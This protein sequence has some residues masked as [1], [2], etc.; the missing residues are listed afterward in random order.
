MRLFGVHRLE[1]FVDEAILLLQ[2]LK[3]NLISR[4]RL[5]DFF[6]LLVDLGLGEKEMVV[7][8]LFLEVVQL[9]LVH[10]DDSS[11]TLIPVQS[12]PSK[13]AIRIGPTII[14]LGLLVEISSPNIVAAGSSIVYRRVRKLP[15][16]FKHVLVQLLCV[17]VDGLIYRF[18]PT[19]VLFDCRIH[20]TLQFYDSWCY[21]FWA[22]AVIFSVFC[23]L[24]VLQRC[25]GVTDP[26]LISKSILPLVLKCSPFRICSS[27]TTSMTFCVVAAIFSLLEVLRKRNLF[28]YI[29]LTIL[30]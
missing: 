17:L 20:S 30:A 7:H 6:I 14:F 23:L 1:H 2:L 28:K 16:I 22:L 24:Y 11:G 9:W 21:R 19:K 27:D 8:V 13:I 26:R 5:L 15:S 4:F 12:I 29:H 3:Q 25:V 18:F 10:L